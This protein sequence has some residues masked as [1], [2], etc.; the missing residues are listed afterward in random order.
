VGYLTYGF[1]A[2][3][4]SS[5]NV[6]DHISTLYEKIAF[7]LSAPYDRFDPKFTRH[8][9]KVKSFKLKPYLAME[10]QS[11]KSS[12]RAILRKDGPD[13]DETVEKI[14][15]AVDM[16]DRL[17]THGLLFIKAFLLKK[18]EDDRGRV[19]PFPIVN[20]KFTLNALRVLAGIRPD[21]G[22]DISIQQK[23]EFHDFFTQH[24][25]A[26]MPQGEP[27]MTMKNMTSVM[28]Y[29]S[30]EM[31]VCYETNIKQHWM[32]HVT[33]YVNDAH[34]KTERTRQINEGDG[35]AAEKKALRV[36]LYHELDAV[37]NDL[38][39]SRNDI[40]YAKQSLLEYHNWINT[41]AAFIMPMNQR[42]VLNNNVMYDIAAAPQDYLY[43]MVYMGDYR[44]V[45]AAL[46]LTSVKLLSVF[47]LNT[48]LTP[49]SIRLDT[50]AVH[51]LLDPNRRA[52][53]LRAGTLLEKKL[54][55]WNLLFKLN[56]PIFSGNRGPTG[57]RFHHQI[58]TD[59]ISVTVLLV[60]VKQPQAD[61]IGNHAGGGQAPLQPG[62]PYLTTITPQQR[63]NL[64][65]KVLVGI[66]PGLSD[67]L[68]CVNG[69]NHNAA[70]TQYRYTQNTRR[71]LLGIGK[72][73]KQLQ[74]MK[75]ATLVDGRTVSAWEAQ[76]AVT[77]SKSCDFDSFVAYLRFKNLFNF[78]LR[79]FYSRTIFRRRRL[80]Q[81]GKKQQA[82]M[83]LL[84]E[85]KLNFHEQADP[86]DVVVAFGD[87]EQKIHR[88][89]EPTKG[90]GMRSLFEKAGYHVF[91]INEFRTSKM[92]SKC[93]DGDCQLE[94]FRWVENPRPHRHDFILRH[95]LL[96]CRNCW[97]MWNRDVN[98][99]VN[100]WK[101]A[102]AILTAQLPPDDANLR[103]HY[104]RRNADANNNA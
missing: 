87:W 16:C 45:R 6:R 29:L 60:R 1:L 97:T 35:T 39:N 33:R 93:S 81:Y 9:L 91:L 90:K 32:K 54:A 42:I 103:P 17:W 41:A 23:Q 102:N 13:V 27:V 34:R 40:P 36:A 48:S 67:I 20:E 66:D 80:T 101:I 14:Q 75:D 100:M 21:K 59:G 98:A 15:T 99:A 73:R 84:K 7:I 53:N 2:T 28:S 12:L 4:L 55:L 31:V 88:F 52:F 37:R 76:G 30:Q 8:G 96:R 69:A 5:E 77:N 3:E 86:N 63:V 26:T 24:Y 83:K 57:F 104:L 79:P 51:H 25:R 78:K 38:V 74:K 58:V 19:R 22:D 49:R 44:G 72:N 94:K 68:Y 11:K 47:P 65:E 82:D 56:K 50:T 10:F 46:N 64:A 85:F 62:T 71:R 95:G 43:G 89:H 70:Q 18:Y 61:G 92:C